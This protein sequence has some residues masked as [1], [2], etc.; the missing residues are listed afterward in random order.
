MVLG[1]F[2]A[3]LSTS[4]SQQQNH[5]ENHQLTAEEQANLERVL[6]FLETKAMGVEQLTSRER[7]ILAFGMQ[8]SQHKLREQHTTEPLELE[9]V[10]QLISNLGQNPQISEKLTRSE[11]ENDE[12]G[13]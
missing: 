6:W 13:P 11:E 9:T 10:E 4:T 5:Q 3:G 8:L 1:G 2:L 7:L 12:I